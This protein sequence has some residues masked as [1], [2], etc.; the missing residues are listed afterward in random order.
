MI[1][2]QLGAYTNCNRIAGA[3]GQAPGF[4]PPI[5][6]VRYSPLRP[7]KSEGQIGFAPKG[8]H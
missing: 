2:H 8:Q 5:L 3:G 4:V 6:Q 1:E 7:L